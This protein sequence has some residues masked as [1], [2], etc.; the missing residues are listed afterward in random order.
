MQNKNNITKVYALLA[1]HSWPKRRME[2]KGETSKRYKMF[3]KKTRKISLNSKILKDYNK[4]QDLTTSKYVTY[5]NNVNNTVVMS[6]RGTDVTLIEENDFYTDALLLLGKEKNRSIYKNSYN[7]LKQIYK[8]YPNYK[9][10]L[11][12]A[13]LGGRVAIDLLDSDL[14]EKLYE[15]HVFNTATVPLNLYKSA[16]CHMDN[17]TKKDMKF[18]NNR[19]KLHINLVNNDI[20]SIL[21]LGEKAKTKKVFTRKKKSA[22]YLVGKNKNIKTNHSI[23]NFI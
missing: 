23:M 9:V 12:G 10:I 17:M 15:V 11:L 14:G 16:V 3:Y 4:I 13:S 8:K 7:N 6:I 20:I 21:S 1:L 22:R 2:E 18:C 19:D 5:I